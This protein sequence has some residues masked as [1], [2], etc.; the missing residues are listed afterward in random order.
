MELC[1]PRADAAH[2]VMGRRKEKNRDTKK[3]SLLESLNEGEAAIVLRRLLVAHPEL[4]TEAEEIAKGLLRY[5][6]F[7][8]IAEDVYESGAMDSGVDSLG[9]ALCLRTL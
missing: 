5:D 3:N 4:D 6:N 2:I 8:D 1:F 7:E 9:I